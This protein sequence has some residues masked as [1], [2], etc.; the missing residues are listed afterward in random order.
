[1]DKYDNPNGA[2]PVP[3]AIWGGEEWVMPSESGV[4]ENGE[5]KVWPSKSNIPV[6]YIW[7]PIA[8]GWS[9]FSDQV[10]WDNNYINDTPTKSD[11]AQR[12]K[13]IQSRKTAINALMNENKVSKSAATKGLAEAKAVTTEANDLL[14]QMTDDKSSPADIASQKAIA[15]RAAQEEYA[16]QTLIAQADAYNAHAEADLLRAD[17][18]SLDLT[19]NESNNI[20]D[21]VKAKENAANE[22]DK[23]VSQMQSELARREAEIAKL[24]A[25]AEAKGMKADPSPKGK[26]ERIRVSAEWDFKT[27]VVASNNRLKV[28]QANSN[29][30]QQKVAAAKSTLAKLNNT[31]EGLALTDP[32]KHPYK[33]STNHSI[34]VSDPTFRGKMD[35]TATALINNKANLNYLLSHTGLDYKRNILKDTKIVVSDDPQGDRAIYAAETQEWD[36]LRQKLL[37]ARNEITKASSNLNK[38]TDNLKVK[39]KEKNSA[40]IDFDA[41]KDAVKFTADFYATAF[42]KFGEKSAILAR[43]LANAAKGKRIRSF[44]EAMASYNANGRTINN[45]LS[46]SDRLAIHNALESVNQAQMASMMGKFA[47]GFGLTSTAID[48]YDLYAEIKVGFKTGEWK[49]AILQAE[50]LVAGKFASALVAFTFSLILATPMGVVGYA[51]LMTV[52]G[53]LITPELLDKINGLFTK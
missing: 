31:P 44:D 40:Q 48:W 28:A 53:A 10:M 37:N 45:R 5:L 49:G 33:T 22:L 21:R 36:K 18:S 19:H 43:D 30:A 23:K 24:E 3:G 50:G 2:P 1:M 35:V 39:E 34:Y 32:A 27:S 46:S 11:K 52:V 7:K 12:N 4:T 42:D 17:A 8:S 9:S 29:L 26:K 25:D 13:E 16:N 51:V 6:D 38:E 47:K 20:H 41:I 14:K 15:A